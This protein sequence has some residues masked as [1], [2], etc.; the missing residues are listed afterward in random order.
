MLK[1]NEE[2]ILQDTQALVMKKHDNLA[3]IKA[4]ATAYAIAHGYDAEKTARFVEFTQGIEDNGLSAEESVKLE[5]LSSYIDEF[6]E[7]S[8]GEVVKCN[9]VPATDGEVASTTFSIITNI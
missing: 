6:E 5:I 8:E 9:V 1:V 7:I 2:K 3:K 4:D